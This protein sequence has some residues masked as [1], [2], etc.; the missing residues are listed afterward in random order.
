MGC[1]YYTNTYLCFRTK[2]GKNHSV[3]VGSE[4]GYYYF[5]YDSDSE[6]DYE[7]KEA[8]FL[9]EKN[10]KV[11][12]ADGAWKI[13]SK[14]KQEYYLSLLEGDESVEYTLSD[15]VEITKTESRAERY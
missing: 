13:S 1:D 5:S 7:R 10:S 3:Y 9:A 4:K 2:D 12:F 11:M 14:S 6:G 15:I 8:S